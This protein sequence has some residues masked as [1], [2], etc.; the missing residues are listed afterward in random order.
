[1]PISSATTVLETV[2]PL[3]TRPT[4]YR[5]LSFCNLMCK[6]FI[7]PH[8]PIFFCTLFS[9]QA[10]QVLAQRMPRGIFRACP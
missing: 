2:L 7:L 10:A 9:T 6:S 3:G 1:M 4:L 8:L 5:S